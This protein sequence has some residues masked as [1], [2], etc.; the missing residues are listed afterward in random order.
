MRK[1][2][3]AADAPN[4]MESH[5]DQVLKSGIG[6]RSLHPQAWPVANTACFIYLRPSLRLEKQKSKFTRRPERSNAPVV[7]SGQ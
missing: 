7:C 1:Q 5:V 3:K 6:R 4:E 2:T